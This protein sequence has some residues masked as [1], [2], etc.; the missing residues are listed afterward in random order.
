MNAQQRDRLLAVI[1]RDAAIR[2]RYVNARGEFCIIGGMLDDCGIDVKGAF[3][4]K[5]DNQSDIWDGNP[6]VF[7]LTHAFGL[8]TVELGTLQFL[9]DINSDRT[10]RR[11]A[12]RRFV[13][14]LPLAE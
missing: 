3:Y 4:R 9:N 5:W 10:K 7:R 12:L 2:R 11:A 8:S 6:Y 1:D 13:N 14:T